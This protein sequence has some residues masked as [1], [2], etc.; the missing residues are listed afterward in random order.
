MKL[1]VN[2][3]IGTIPSEIGRA[4]ALSYLNL[5][6]NNL[7]GTIPTETVPPTLMWWSLKIN[8]QL[9]GSIPTELAAVSNM[10]VMYLEQTQLTGTIPS[11][12]CDFRPVTQI[13]CD[14]LDCDCCK[15]YD[16]DKQDYVPCADL[17]E[18]SHQNP[19]S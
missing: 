5:H 16:Q 12:I 17:P 14:E 3:L 9:S 8:F 15:G 11:V 4:T 1:A 18:Q 13:D 19:N 7:S 2:G 10:T 6:N